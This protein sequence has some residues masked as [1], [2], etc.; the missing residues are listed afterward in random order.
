MKFVLLSFNNTEQYS[1]LSWKDGESEIG[2]E[3]KEIFWHRRV[4][5]KYEAGTPRVDIM[6]AE[7]MLHFQGDFFHCYLKLWKDNPNARMQGGSNVF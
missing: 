6:S 3:R 7:T 5:G 1:L 4:G 2:K